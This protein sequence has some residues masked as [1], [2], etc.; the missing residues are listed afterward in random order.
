MAAL[1]EIGRE[2]QRISER[3]AQLDA[4]RT[5]L[6]DQLNDL[7]TAARMLKRFGGQADTT[8]GRRGGHSAGTTLATPAKNRAQGGQQ[9]PSVLLSDASLKAVQAH[10]KGASSNDVL[11]YLSRR[12][13]IRH[14]RRASARDAGR[15]AAALRPLDG[16]Y[17]HRRAGDLGRLQRRDHRCQIFRDRKMV[18]AAPAR[19]ASPQVPKL[20]IHAMTCEVP[21]NWSS[22]TPNRSVPRKLAPKPMQE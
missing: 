4:E 14:S 1:D 5:K 2:K 15:I 10:R 17:G 3:L 6:S 13:G 11:S 8:K 21:P 12:F 7:E 18:A 16:S 20:S 19:Q 9:P 22:V